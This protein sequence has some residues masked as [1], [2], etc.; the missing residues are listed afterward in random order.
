MPLPSQTARTTSSGRSAVYRRRKR[1]NG[2]PPVAL[3]GGLLGL[4]ALGFAAWIAVKMI[5]GVGTKAKA[6]EVSTGAGAA[7]QDASKVAGSPGPR[8]ANTPS[9][10][11]RE[12]KPVVITQGGPARGEADRP[13]LAPPSGADAPQPVDP[14]E[15]MP[16]NL[17]ADALAQRD[18]EAT[19]GGA[20]T[21][22]TPLD[23][24]PTPTTPSGESTTATTGGNSGTAASAA[25]AQEA[26]TAAK[27]L[28]ERSDPLAARVVLSD[29]LRSPAVDEAGRRVL[30]AELTELNKTLVFGP[31]V[32]AGDPLTESYEI[33]SGD[34]LAT[35]A[36]RRGLE[37]HWKLIARVNGITNPG[38]IRVGQKVKLVRGPF[39]AIV[40]KSEFR[41]D[42]YQG[43]PEEPE[44]WTFVR[45]FEVG[46]GEGDSTPIGE[47]IIKENSKLENPGWVNPR[48][49]A[50]QYSGNDP[51][52]PIGDYW[53]GLD[54]QGE[55]AVYV[56]FGLH[57][58]IEPDS[59][60]KMASMGCVR[61]LPDDIAMIYECL[62]DGIS[63]VKIVQ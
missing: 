47:F 46:L 58:T 56:G 28:M 53:L 25:V 35:I 26:L 2:L 63:R 4:A 48:N 42:L 49:P 13:S 57:G 22:V 18:G 10:P 54:G 50:E 19:P 34:R 61:M 41:L 59:I 27:R 6:G 23:A 40:D 1:G 3:A 8:T 29:A 62:S 33:Q 14:L 11:E 43:P 45:S 12:I 37:T 30:R 31:N 38:R 44:R 32:V 7:D 5:D 51:R 20:V 52:N 15:P 36:S 21:P 16:R 24:P 39:H 55:A 60:G 17:L 9:T